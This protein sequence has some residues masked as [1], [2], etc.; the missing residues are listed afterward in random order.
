[1]ADEV[2]EEDL[3]HSIEEVDAKIRDFRK[4]VR[5]LLAD[6][7]SKSREAPQSKRHADAT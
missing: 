7:Q 3:L 1:M 4:R 6:I 2:I 5:A